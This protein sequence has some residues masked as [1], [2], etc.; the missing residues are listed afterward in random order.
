MQWMQ[1]WRWLRHCMKRSPSFA[2]SHW[3]HVPMQAQEMF[4][5]YLF[6]C[7]CLAGQ[8]GYYVLREATRFY[9]I[10]QNTLYLG[11][12]SVPCNCTCAVMPQ[13]SLKEGVRHET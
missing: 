4:S 8:W 11:S 10:G 7:L 13:C 5:R 12:F 2:R 1:P 9:D 6:S 3:T